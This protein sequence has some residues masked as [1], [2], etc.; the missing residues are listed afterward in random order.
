MK[1]IASIP[2]YNS[3]RTLPRAI[4]AV[5]AQTVTPARIIV[6][7]DG[8]TDGSASCAAEAG[9]VVVPLGAN[10]GRGAARARLLA[11]SDADLLFMCD[12]GLQPPP[13]FLAKALP[14]FDDP[15]AGAVFGHITQAPPRTLAERWRGRHLFKTDPPAAP[16]AD[17]LLGTGVCVLRVEAARAAGGFNPALRSGE[18]ADLG[19]RLLAAGWKVIADPALHALNLSADS[20][21]KAL[22]RYAR[23]NSPGGLRGRDW[24]R[25][26]V[27]AAKVMAKADLR[28]RDP[29]AALLSMAAPFYQLRRR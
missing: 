3:A 23:W 28:A 13:D 15:L 9:A 1:L 2:V 16:R 17:A 8:S 21:G 25:Q 5:R 6:V 14:W 26:L 24:W 29:M 20:A 4:A 18:D 10:L 11:E 12:A 7:D 19:R 22:E 27:Y